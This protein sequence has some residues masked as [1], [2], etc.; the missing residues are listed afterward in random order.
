VPPPVYLGWAA[1]AMNLL[2]IVL[3]ARLQFL[4]RRKLKAVEAIQK[5]QEEIALLIEVTM[6][7]ASK[8]AQGTSTTH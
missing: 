5:E 7:V 6:E 1:L 2:A 8:D 3:N 4:L